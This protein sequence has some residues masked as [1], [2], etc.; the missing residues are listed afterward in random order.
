[1]FL[2]GKIQTD[3]YRRQ[4]FLHLDT[5][6]KFEENKKEC[7]Y[8]HI[9]RVEIGWKMTLVSLTNGFIYFIQH[10][11][12]TESYLVQAIYLDS[13]QGWQNW[14]TRYISHSLE[15]CSDLRK[16]RNISHHFLPSLFFSH[17]LTLFDWCDTIGAFHSLIITI[18]FIFC[19][20][21]SFV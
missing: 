3:I 20:Q 5:K 9:C 1:M 8:H 21:N 16:H 12:H 11:H 6:P 10:I 15:I 19:E 18:L 13:L 14:C 2:V 17:S 4:D 7:V